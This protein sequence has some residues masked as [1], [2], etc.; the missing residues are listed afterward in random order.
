[1]RMN[2]KEKSE[3]KK[4]DEANCAETEKKDVKE[5]KE[6]KKAP[7][8]E[9][10][11][12]KEENETGDDLAGALKK[13]VDDLTGQ[14]AKLKNAYAMAYADTENTRKR[15]QND[16]EQRSKYQIQG[17]ALEVL[18]V[19]DNCER[20]LAQATTDEAYRKGVEMIYSQLKTALQ[21]EGVEEIDALNQPFDGNW[22][23]AL[24]SEKKDGV[25]PGI[26]IEVLQKGYKLKDRLLRAAMV[27]VSE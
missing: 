20:A 2:Q 10:K 12:K 17:F 14:V 9:K 11:D 5:S 24:M 8:D 21:K 15:L 13:Q 22:H 23:Q 7:A 18:P 1:M 16:F 26:C 3:E 19:L 6:V 4:Q 27:K 25:E